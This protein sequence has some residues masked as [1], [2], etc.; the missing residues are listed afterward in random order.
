MS[1]FFIIT[2]ATGLILSLLSVVGGFGHFHLGHLHLDHPIAHGH[3]PH[4][5]GHNAGIS[6]V[7][8]FTVLAFLTWFG[9]VGYLLH[10]SAAFPLSVVL[11]LAV[12]SGFAGAALLWATLFKVLLPHERVLDVADT[13]MGGVLA[14]V[15]NGIRAGDGVGEIIFSQTGARR[16]SAARSEDGHAI[17]RGVEVVVIRYERGVAYVRRWDEDANTDLPS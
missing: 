16:A 9:G 12:V 5:G 10:R 15:S 13:E 3:G 2:F 14:R 6:S 1:T 17:D 4:G 11:V 7:N 8:A